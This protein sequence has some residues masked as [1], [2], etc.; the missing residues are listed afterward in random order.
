[1]PGRVR[2]KTATIWSMI[3]AIGNTHTHCIT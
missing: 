3:R 2:S 1:M